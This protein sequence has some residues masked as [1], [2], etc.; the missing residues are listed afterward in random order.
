MNTSA[1][2]APPWTLADEFRPIA[3]ELLQGYF[4]AQPEAGFT[5]AHFERLGGGGDRPE[6]ADEFTAEDLVAVT[7]LSVKVPAEAALRILGPDRSR[8]SELL[9]E[10]PT[11]RD[12]V[13]VG[14]AEIDR[15]WAP[16][17]LD[18]ALSDLTGLG[19]TTVSKLIARKRPRLIPIYDREVNKVLA[20]NKGPLWRP[21][22]EALQVDGR[23]LHRN[24]LALRDEAGI[25]S[26]ITPLRVL[27]VIVWR[28]G[29]GHADKLRERGINDGPN[30][31]D[32]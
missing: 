10:I 31:A 19:R 16:W 20:L 29:K 2:L 15:D 3:V 23:A 14:P 13:D 8:L 26:D 9:H 17:L 5:G 6:L 4:S 12:L 1:P 22:A 7:L 24:L 27:D 21:L 11:N 18:D 30:G 25:G 28:T 32:S